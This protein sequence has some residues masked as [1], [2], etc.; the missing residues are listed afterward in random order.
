[1]KKRLGGKGTRTRKTNISKANLNK[2]SKRTPKKSV[3]QKKNTKKI[4]S[5]AK[6]DFQIDNIS[7]L[8]DPLPFKSKNRSKN[9]IY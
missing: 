1:M 7:S 4:P 3:I 6:S 8:E 9:Y 2:K 5:K